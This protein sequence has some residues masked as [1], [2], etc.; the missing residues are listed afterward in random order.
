MAS[1]SRLSQ[2]DI[3]VLGAVVAA[4]AWLAGPELGAHFGRIKGDPSSYSPKKGPI[5]RA[6]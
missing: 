3:Q 4:E 5:A 1:A 6:I 2:P